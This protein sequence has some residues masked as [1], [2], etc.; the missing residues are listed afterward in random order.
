MK[1]ILLILALALPVYGA[2]AETK[3]TEVD[4]ANQVE[5]LSQELQVPFATNADRL[6]NT[7]TDVVT[8]PS[9][10]DL[11]RTHGPRIERAYRA[12]KDSVRRGRN[13]GSKILRKAANYKADYYELFMTVK[14][15]LDNTSIYWPN[16]GYDYK[17]CDEGTIAFTFKG[18]TKQIWLCQ[19][20]LEEFIAEKSMAQVL[21]H[22]SAH[23]TGFHKEC[24][25]TTIEVG[26]MVLS[27]EGLAF[28]NAYMKKC[29]LN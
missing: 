6:L 7:H 21:I 25:A 12:V 3:R 15:R 5:S 29:G 24:D 8:D 18:E 1:R 13:R 17:A 16:P 28:E 14:S 22:E 20:A 26:A 23:L 10:T 4:L 2:Q 19:L 9:S 27:D 11:V